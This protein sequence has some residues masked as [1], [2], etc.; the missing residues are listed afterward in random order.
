MQESVRQLR[1]STSLSLDEKN[2][3]QA[4]APSGK[5]SR[6]SRRR[7]RNRQ[8]QMEPAVRRVLFKHVRVNRF[9]CRVTY[10]VRSHDVDVHRRDA[11]TA[12]GV[13]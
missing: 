10:Q 4:D 3:S 7:K 9:H 1:H 2:W 5:Q 13:G 6:K 11:F 8:E 12:R